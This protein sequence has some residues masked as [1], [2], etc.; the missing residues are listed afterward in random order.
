[1]KPGHRPPTNDIEA[2]FET[3][4][5]RS[6]PSRMFHDETKTMEIPNTDFVVV[7]HKLIID[8]FFKKLKSQALILSALALCD[9]NQPLVSSY[10]VLKHHFS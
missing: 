6:Y 7:S 9:S 1:M 4:Q 8:H 3:W 5:M 2:H 10:H